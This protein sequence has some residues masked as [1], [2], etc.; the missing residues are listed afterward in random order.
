MPYISRPSWL[1]GGPDQAEQKPGSSAGGAA[2]ASPP[3]SAP[4]AGGAA[5]AGQF[6]T[7]FVNLSNYLQEGRPQAANYAEQNIVR[8]LN[9]QIVGVNKDA[10]AQANRNATWEQAQA[11][12]T[13]AETGNEGKNLVNQDYVDWKNEYDRLWRLQGNP[14][15]SGSAGRFKRAHPAPPETTGALTDLP[16]VPAKPVADPALEARATEVGDSKNAAMTMEGRGTLFNRAA[17]QGYGYGNFD[18]YLSGGK[19]WAGVEQSYPT[20]WNQIKGKA[21][22][23][24][25]SPAEMGPDATPAVAYDAKGVPKKPVAAT[26]TPSA[27]STQPTISTQPAGIAL[28][29]RSLLTRR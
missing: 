8:P 21:G 19:P 6:G 14:F 24:G 18:S 9:Q 22:G 29:K 25:A 10:T 16:G 11:A 15:L 4:A 28:N 27:V 7:G 13:A 1:S 17:G 20:L 5:P 23:P 12:R 2:G 3:G 26:T